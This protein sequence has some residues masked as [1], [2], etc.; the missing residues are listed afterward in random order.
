MTDSPSA[1]EPGLRSPFGRVF[2]EP[3]ELGI[4]CMPLR[5]TEW[6]L[7]IVTACVRIE[8]MRQKGGNERLRPGYYCLHRDIPEISWRAF[9]DQISKCIG[10]EVARGFQ[11]FEGGCS[12]VRGML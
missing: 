12:L 4:L 3:V 5:D 6:S 9:C 8:T 2:E 7:V 10:A 11:F 1:S